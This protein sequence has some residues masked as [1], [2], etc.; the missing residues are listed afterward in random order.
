MNQAV[1][2]P[3]QLRQFASHLHRFA[4]DLK[5]RST[6]LG[7]QMNQLEQTWR[8]EQQRKFAGEFSDQ[9]RQLS[10]MIQATE[11]HIPYLLRK[12]EQ[13]ETYLGR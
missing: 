11:Q 12:A 13:I 9:L 5:E 3:E 1:V 10:R 4:E 6:A 8:D 2:D 7:T